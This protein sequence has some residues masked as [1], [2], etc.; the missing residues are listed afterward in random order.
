MTGPIGVTGPTGV[1][2]PAKAA[3]RAKMAVD[4]IIPSNV[5]TKIKF[6]TKV[7]DNALTYDSTNTR[8]TP[9]AGIVFI[10]AGIFFSAGVRSS[11]Y[12]LVMIYK[13]GT[14]IAQNGIPTSTNASPEM[15]VVDQANG[16]DYYEVYA[17]CAASGTGATVQAINFATLFYGAVL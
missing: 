14:N 2:P 17:N 7:F 11:A 15:T 1:Q 10:G 5:N 16:T 4:Q 3:F 12:P 8:W 13:N 6:A 9:P